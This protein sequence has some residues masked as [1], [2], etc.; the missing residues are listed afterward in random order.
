MFLEGVE[1]WQVLSH[2]Q[3]LLG[4]WFA[5]FVV[6][7]TYVGMPVLREK[8][9][10]EEGRMVAS[11]AW[12]ES[13]YARRSMPVPQERTYVGASFCPVVDAR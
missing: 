5:W 11:S 8:A 7:T 1:M 13:G 9:A 3:C 10:N 4:V 6:S 12:M 2:G